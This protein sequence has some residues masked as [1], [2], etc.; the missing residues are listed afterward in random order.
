MDSPNDGFGEKEEPNFCFTFKFPTYE[1]FIKNRGKNGDFDGF[2]ACFATNTSKYE[3]IYGESFSGFIDEL[4]VMGSEVKKVNTDTNFGFLL[5]EG[6]KEVE[7]DETEEFDELVS[8]E[9][10]VQAVNAE[11]NL[12]GD[13]NV[14]EGVKFSTEKENFSMERN[15]LDSILT[16]WI[17]SYGDGYLSDGEFDTQNIEDQNKESRQQNLETFNLNF[18][19]KKEFDEQLEK[20]KLADEQNDDCLY[21][22][23]KLKKSLVFDSEETNKL[24]TLW[25]HQ[26]LI[27]QLQMEIKKVRATG[28]PTILEESECPNKIMMEDIKPWKIDDNK[29]HHENPMGELHKLYKSYRE[30]MR[31][32]DILNYQKMYALGQSFRYLP[33]CY[34]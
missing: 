2:E 11:N 31:K 7:K 19:S 1:E 17:D 6:F 13:E 4:K 10:K 5:D 16:H 8:T 28:L 3:F 33:N 9:E 32:F 21:D 15:H 23:E 27:E 34:C 26:E 12:V 30:R 14:S 25:E 29:F 20:P 18:L 22:S 24:E